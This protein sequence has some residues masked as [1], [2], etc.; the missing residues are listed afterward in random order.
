MN[1][2]RI[3][4][5][6]RHRFFNE[7]FEGGY[8][9]VDFGM[10]IDLTNHLSDSVEEFRRFFKPEYLEKHP[11]ATPIKAG[12]ACSFTYRV[13]KLLGI[14]DLVLSP[15]GTGKYHIGEIQGEYYYFASKESS[16]VRHRRKIIK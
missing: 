15:D 8:I 16:C 5:G 11:N 9:G 7:C 3:V 4:L 13:T 14:G 1:I 10:D 6:G 2:L 12:L